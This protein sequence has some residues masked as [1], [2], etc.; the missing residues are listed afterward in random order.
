MSDV[1]IQW[2][3][4]FAAAIELELAENRP[5]L[6]Y[7]KE[8]NLNSKPLEIDLL[9]IK[10]DNDTPIANEIGK[11]FRKHNI[12]EYKSPQDHLN[13]DT[14]YKTGAYASLYKSY[15]ETVNARPADTITVSIVR[16][17]RPNGLFRYF[18]DHNI[19]YCNP[20]PGIYY[21]ENEVLF[22][23][24]I[25]VTKELSGTEHT[26][27]KALSENLE[28][29]DLEHLLQKID[30]L[31]WNF[32]RVLADSVLEV[33]VRANK[34]IVSKLRGDEHMCQALLEIMEPEINKIKESVAESVT[35]SVTESVTESVTKS[36]TKSVTESNLLNTVKSFRSLGI[37]ND[38]IIELLITNFGL[39]PQ[40]AETFL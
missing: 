38:Q 2:H 31:Q 40:K 16:E 30:R 21:V 14:F 13:I 36:V 35:K 1:K 29:S 15:G 28:K 4:G 18:K 10:K 8:Y 20:Y 3:S 12:L 33:A 9:V 5:D 6:T 32:D 27:L 11:I 22:Q 24:Q 37:G 7:M 23:T 34:K 26:W 39:S 19:L 17:T 25:I